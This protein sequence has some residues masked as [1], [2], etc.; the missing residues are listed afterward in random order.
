VKT[1][2]LAAAAGLALAAA[3]PA[4]EWKVIGPGGGGAQARPP[5]SL[6]HPKTGSIDQTSPNDHPGFRNHDRAGCQA[7]QIGANSAVDGHYEC[8]EYRV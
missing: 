1:R 3:I 4:T 2:L 8:P 7:N 6:H 5:V